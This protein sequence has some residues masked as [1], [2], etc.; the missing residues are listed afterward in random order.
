MTH[1]HGEHLG[2]ELA[3]LWLCGRSYLPAAADGVFS[4]YS[5]VTFS[6]VPPSGPMTRVYPVWEGLRKELQKVLK[7]STENIYESG[8]ALVRVADLYAAQDTEA[9]KS[10]KVEEGKY[11]SDKNFYI[12]DR[13]HRP[14]LPE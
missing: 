10:M 8:D 1:S 2:V 9:A 14:K 5:M 7:Q 3:E 13:A 6:I 4:A 12:E 11:T